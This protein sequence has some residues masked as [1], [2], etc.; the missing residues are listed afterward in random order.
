M[1]HAGTNSRYRKPKGA[2]RL[3]SI[4]TSNRPDTTSDDGYWLWYLAG[5]AGLWFAYLVVLLTTIE[6]SLWDAAKDSLANMV[7]P[8]FL[9]LLARPLIARAWSM[10]PA[11]IVMA[12]VLAA[13]TYALLWY[14]CLAITLGLANV[15][16]GESFRLVWLGG[17]GRV[18]QVYQGMLLFALIATFA[19]FWEMRSRW[20][21]SSKAA[22]PIVQLQERALEPA[23]ILL[24]TDDGLRPVETINI[25]AIEASDDASIVVL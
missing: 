6:Q 22:T 5:C 18:W 4:E 3:Q 23:T 20:L 2:R 12:L 13:L 19:A 15:V 11:K 17:I 16:Q 21:A 14:G 25:L 10:R 24:K 7:P 1:R 9:G 8:A